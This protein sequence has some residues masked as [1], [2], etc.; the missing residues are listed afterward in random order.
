MEAAVGRGKN[1]EIGPMKVKAIFPPALGKECDKKKRKAGVVDSIIKDMDASASDESIKTEVRQR[2]QMTVLKELGLT[3]DSVKKMVTYYNEAKEN[4]LDSGY[5]TMISEFNERQEALK[6]HE[7]AGKR[8][9]SVAIK[10]LDL[11][12]STVVDIIG[13]VF[14]IAKNVVTGVADIIKESTENKKKH[15]IFSVH[16]PQVDDKMIKFMEDQYFPVEAE[17]E[18][19]VASD[20]EMLVSQYKSF[21]EKGD[22]EGFTQWI[23]KTYVNQVLQK[24]KLKTV[25]VTTDEDYERLRAS[26]SE[27]ENTDRN[28][29]VES[30]GSLPQTRVDEKESSETRPV[31][32][33]KTEEDPFESINEISREIGKEMRG[34]QISI[35][36][37]L[38]IKTT[39]IKFSEDVAKIKNKLGSQCFTTPSGMYAR[40]TEDVNPNKMSCSDDCVISEDRRVFLPVSRYEKLN[41]NERINMITESAVKPAS[42]GKS[43]GK[44]TNG[45]STF[46]G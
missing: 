17:L 25:K 9:R 41:M 1:T 10:I 42:F 38:G 28:E 20:G 46:G 13:S 30:Q 27:R 3:E 8:K 24:F 22:E 6:E 5:R 23:T 16:T 15:D 37:D 45:A 36:E 40:T 39:R 18:S 19:I 21:A 34:L 26:V 4:P 44:T 14:S 29:P 12:V 33:D 7:N 43:K 11:V 32:E 35:L 31:E 2:L